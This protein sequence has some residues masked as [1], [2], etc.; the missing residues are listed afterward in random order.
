M[1]NIDVI[2]GDRFV[3][4]FFNITFEMMSGSMV[5]D[6]FMFDRS[7]YTS[8][9]VGSSFGNGRFCLYGEMTDYASQFGKN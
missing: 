4:Q 9:V 5:F 8:G 2:P 3:S 7:F 6:V 1:L